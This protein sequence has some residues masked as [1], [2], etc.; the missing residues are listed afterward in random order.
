MEISE[1]LLAAAAADATQPRWFVS[2]IVTESDHPLRADLDS[3]LSSIAPELVDQH[4][5]DPRYQWIRPHDDLHA[6]IDVLV[7]EIT[8][9]LYNSRRNALCN[10]DSLVPAPPYGHHAL[11][12]LHPD[13]DG[14][15]PVSALRP[16][17]ACWTRA[18]FVFHLPPTLQE[19]NS[20]Y[21]TA[22]HLLRLDPTAQ[23]NLRLDPL[24][25]CPADDYRSA[26][27]RM[28]VY[29]RPL[30][31]DRLAQLKSE[32]HAQWMP[33]DLHSAGGTSLTQLCWT[34]RDDGVHFKC[35]E[36]PSDADARP[37]RYVHA[38]YNPETATITH[39]DG[40]VRYYTADELS[41]RHES[42]VRTAG[43]QGVRVKLFRTD[44][45]LDRDTWCNVVA[46]FFVWNG[47]MQGYFAG[48]RQ[49]ESAT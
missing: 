29:G 3:A 25:I 30:D 23:L 15:V 26:E 14:L 34:P 39:F 5:A 38:I 44:G 49:L 16:S 36:L 40:A 24:L 33:D 35:E 32:E 13:H 46:A 17:Y 10:L 11:E 7:A 6:R 45:A 37:A 12:G 22:Q 2:D 41:L 9:R 43:K 28:V 20:S 42:H 19:M 1:G 31:W 27:Y 18:G 8:Q 4:F 21:W 47:D 48:Q